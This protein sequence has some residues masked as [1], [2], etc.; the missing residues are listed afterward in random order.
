MLYFQQQSVS[1]IFLLRKLHNTLEPPVQCMRMMRKMFFLKNGVMTIAKQA[2]E[3]DSN[4]MTKRG[5]AQNRR[6]RK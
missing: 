2:T 5:K 4:A 1:W 6:K 3:E